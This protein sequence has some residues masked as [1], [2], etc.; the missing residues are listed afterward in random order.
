MKHTIGITLGACL[1]VGAAAFASPPASQ[2]GEPAG[3]LSDADLNLLV[4]QL[5]NQS[6]RVREAATSRLAMLGFE[7]VERLASRYRSSASPE[8]KMRIKQAVQSMFLRA[9][10]AGRMPEG[11]LGVQHV[12]MDGAE[13]GI[14][15]PVALV[16][17]VVPGSPAEKA[18]VQNADMIVGLGDRPLEHRAGQQFADRVRRLKPGDEVTLSIVRDGKAVQVRAT[19]AAR[20]GFAVAQDNIAEDLAQFTVFWHDR[21]DPSDPIL[22]AAEVGA[23]RM[24][25][26]LAA[27]GDDDDLPV[28]NLDQQ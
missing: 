11:F 16:T 6:F 19:L 23:M 8:Q 15:T 20:A 22:T 28:L 18:G 14:K 27:P 26:I 1:L 21:F 10:R 17:A 2:P 25:F 13:A 9:K 3:Q 24:G 5:A 7:Q 4:E 12:Q